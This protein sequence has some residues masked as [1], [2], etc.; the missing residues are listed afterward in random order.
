MAR[1]RRGELEP[2]KPDPLPWERQRGEP[3][4]AFGYFAM[5]R[6]LGPHRS[7]AKV[8]EATR[9][10]QRTLEAHSSKWRWVERA[11]AYWDWWE[12][13]ERE[14]RE[15]DRAA[16]NRQHLGIGAALAG[17]ALTRLQGRAAAMGPN[18]EPIEPVPPLDPRELDASDVARLVKVGVEIQ[19]VAAGLNTS[20]VS[21]GNVTGSEVVQ[22][23]RDLVEMAARHI[24]EERLTRFMAEVEAY[25]EAGRRAA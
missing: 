16:L 24:P 1:A 22:L 2:R 13:R 17:P 7:I 21:V 4:R 14:R 10:G 20:M 23:A 8:A 12:R 11:D 9:I 5:Y 6:D 25:F 19:R 18:G 3:M 15:G